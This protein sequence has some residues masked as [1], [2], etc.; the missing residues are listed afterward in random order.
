ML[1]A[2]SAETTARTADGL[3]TQLLIMLS[4]NS[5]NFS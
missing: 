1:H 4:D 5:R 3:K 2:I